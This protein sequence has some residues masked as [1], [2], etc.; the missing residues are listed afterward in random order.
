MEKAKLATIAIFFSI[1]MVGCATPSVERKGVAGDE[2]KEPERVQVGQAPV[3]TYGPPMQ[4]V[5]AGEQYGP[6]LQQTHPVVLVLGPG[7]AK[8]F[9]Y[10]GVLQELEKA[11]VTVSAIFGTEMGALIGGLYALGGGVNQLEWRML[12]I[13]REDFQVPSDR[14][15]LFGGGSVGASK[16]ASKRLASLA[17]AFFGSRQIEQSAIPLTLGVGGGAVSSGLMS[18]LVV[19]SFDPEGGTSDLPKRPFLVREAKRLGQGPVVVV[20]VLEDRESASCWDELKEADL[21]IRPDLKGIG[22]EDFQLKTSIVWRGR[23]AYSK[24]AAELKKLTGDTK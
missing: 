4:K 10:L 12:K 17:R 9:A 6:I 16:A 19:Q 22:K 5:E 15:G 20:D 23:T 21:V 24:T 1:A 18:E 14:F 2:R 7:R 11:K 13:K 3:E 8:A